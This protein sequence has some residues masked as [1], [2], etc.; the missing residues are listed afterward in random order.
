MIEMYVLGLPYGYVIIHS[1]K[2]NES[3]QMEALS[4]ARK[5]NNILLE[6]NSCTEYAQV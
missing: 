5:K 2:F 4:V 1:F 3:I 6:H